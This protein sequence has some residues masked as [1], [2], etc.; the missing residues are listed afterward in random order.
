M[1]CALIASV[2]KL[3]VAMPC[4]F[5]ISRL[6]QRIVFVHKER[7]LFRAHGHQLHA[8]TRSRFCVVLSVEAR[9]RK[10]VV[11]FHRFFH[12]ATVNVGKVAPANP[13]RK[14]SV[15][16]RNVQNATLRIRMECAH[17]TLMEPPC[18][19]GPLLQSIIICV[20]IS[21]RENTDF[22]FRPIPQSHGPLCVDS[23]KFDS[24]HI[25]APL[26]N[27]DR[28]ACADC[29]LITSPFLVLKVIYN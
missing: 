9:K 21:R 29:D 26:K 16:K 24:V 13:D 15:R 25:F 5:T 6:Q 1:K 7:V 28:P 12:G 17:K 10:Q 23:D 2:K 20:K 11:V 3:R 22:R 14:S 8:I 27:K 19:C 18:F 4:Y